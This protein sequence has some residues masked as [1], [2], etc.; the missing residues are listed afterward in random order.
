MLNPQMAINGKG[1]FPLTENPLLLSQ[2]DSN[3]HKQNQK[4]LCYHYTIGQFYGAKV[5]IFY[6]TAKFLRIIFT[7]ITPAASS[8]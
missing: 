5:M 8:Q 6:P 7:I 2:A 1:D 3:H 4:L